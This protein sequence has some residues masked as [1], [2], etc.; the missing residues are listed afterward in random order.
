MS[1]LLLIKDSCGDETCILDLECVE[2]FSYGVVY[3][4]LADGVECRAD[5]TAYTKAH[6]EICIESLFLNDG[7]EEEKF[8]R[9]IANRMRALLKAWENAVESWVTPV[10][11]F[12]SLD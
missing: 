1:K 9:K 7:E 5:I 11:D 8:N 2:G 12:S 6:S 10:I 3:E 4:G